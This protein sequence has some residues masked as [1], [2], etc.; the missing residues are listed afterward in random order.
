MSDSVN[1]GG[2]IVTFARAATIEILFEHLRKR[3]P[4]NRELQV[5][6]VREREFDA[7]GGWFFDTLSLD[8]LLIVQQALQ[9]L[10]F[11]PDAAAHWNEDRRPMFYADIERLGQQLAERITQ[12][13]RA[14]N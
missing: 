13:D 4:E 5:L 2:D 7:I 1:F 3:V 8:A 11:A 9:A 14:Q 6:L 10:A 12:F